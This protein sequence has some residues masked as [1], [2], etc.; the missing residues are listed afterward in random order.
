MGGRLRAP[1]TE[2]DPWTA[3]GSFAPAPDEDLL[4]RRA[5]EFGE[6][7]RHGSLVPRLSRRRPSVAATYAPPC[8][9]AC[10]WSGRHVERIE[11]T[12]RRLT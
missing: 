6:V 11:L 5:V 8:W 4:L 10:T 9:P 1:T 2:G 3:V 12:A 7:I